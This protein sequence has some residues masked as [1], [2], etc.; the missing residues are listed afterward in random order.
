MLVQALSDFS[1]RHAEECCQENFENGKSGRSYYE[2][3]LQAGMFAG[4]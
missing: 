1:G 4:I 3:C 2:D